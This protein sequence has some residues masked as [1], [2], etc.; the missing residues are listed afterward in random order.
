MATA[1]YTP[2]LDADLRKELRPAMRAFRTALA[3]DL[4][5]TIRQA[6]RQGKNDVAAEIF[7]AG[8]RPAPKPERADFAETVEPELVAGTPAAD[9]ALGVVVEKRF[10]SEA[11]QRRHQIRALTWASIKSEELLNDVVSTVRDGLDRGGAGINDSLTSMFRG[12]VS[13]GTVDPATGEKLLKPW[14][15]ES[16]HRTEAMKAYNE[17]RWEMMTDPDVDIVVAF[18]YSAILDT[19][20]SPFCRRWNGTVIENTAENRALL[21]EL[22]PP[23]HVHC[24]SLLVPITKFERFA[25]DESLPQAQPQ[26]GFGV[27]PGVDAEAA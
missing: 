9:A 26:R 18:Q 22:V 14:K 21:E 24:R 15:V 5:A 6:A 8:D 10:V 1:E 7:R 20:T 16:I 3:D 23:N 11:L 12:W 27:L 17:G 4:L 19:R 25:A 13:D 2:A